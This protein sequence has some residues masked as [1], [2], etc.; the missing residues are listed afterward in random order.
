MEIRKLFRVAVLGGS[1][2][3]AGLACGGSGRSESP[4]REPG[5]LGG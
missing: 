4:G 2:L 3:S 1:A 5:T